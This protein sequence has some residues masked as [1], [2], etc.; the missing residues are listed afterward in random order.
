MSYALHFLV[1][2]VAGWVQ[3]RM[4]AQ[5]EYLIAENA[6]YRKRLGRAGVRLTDG[7]RPA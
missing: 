6:P 2:T 1:L 5:I 7:Y 4:E 3:R